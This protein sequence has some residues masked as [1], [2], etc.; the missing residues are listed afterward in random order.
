M[1]PDEAA[2]NMTEVDMSALIL[3]ADR[4]HLAAVELLLDAGAAMVRW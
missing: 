1:A 3:A 2:D 4:G